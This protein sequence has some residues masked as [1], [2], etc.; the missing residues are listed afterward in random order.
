G[1]SIARDFRPP[2]AGLPSDDTLRAVLDRTNE[3]RRK[4]N[5]PDVTMDDIRETYGHFY[6]AMMQEIHGTLSELDTRF[7]ALAG[8]DVEIS[9]FVWFQGWN[10]QYETYEQ[11]YASN[12]AHFI[13]DVRADLGAPELPFVIGVMGQN[14]SQPARG[15]MAVIQ[16]AQISMESIPEFA[17]NVR[18]VRTDALVDTAA[19]ALYPEWKERTDEW[20]RVGSDHPYHYLGSAIWFT[21]I[22]HA[23]AEATLD[24]MPDGS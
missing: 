4:N 10:D 18:A 8:A 15:A 19:E 23:L 13:R 21:R 1:K 12:M 2:S 24:L 6:R 17:G 3:N 20:D 5:Q 7:P 16:D 9:G 22:G 11:E 14:G